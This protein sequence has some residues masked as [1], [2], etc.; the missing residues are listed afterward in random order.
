MTFPIQHA[1]LYP[2][3]S[4]TGTE[5][6]LDLTRLLTLDFRPVDEARYPMLALAKQTMRAGGAAPAIYN[7]ANEIAVAAFLENK[8]PFL[9]ISSAVEKTL[10][11]L[12]PDAARDPATLDEVFAVD[13]EAR[14]VAQAI[15]PV[16]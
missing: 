15:L 9:A 7:A 11:A 16:P 4:A 1:L 6:A 10:A 5:R 3:R 13:A 12:A 8:I 14:K 2:A